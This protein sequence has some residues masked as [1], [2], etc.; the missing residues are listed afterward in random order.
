MSTITNSEDVIDSREIIARIDELE[1][2]KMAADQNE[3]GAD[4]NPTYNDEWD[5]EL[6]DELAALK[7]LAKEAQ[8]YS[9]DWR[10]GEQ[11]IRRSYFVDYISDLISDCYEL[12]K[13][14]TSGQ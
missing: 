13:E 14:L 8:D 6:A 11:L 10:H 1:E 2:I 9:S 5:D 4:G 7:I 3:D 12:P